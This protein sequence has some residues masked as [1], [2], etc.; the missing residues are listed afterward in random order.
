M[1]CLYLES[2]GGGAQLLRPL[3]LATNA[4][5]KAAAMTAHQPADNILPVD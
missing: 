5:A 2:G 1:L 3:W 4:S